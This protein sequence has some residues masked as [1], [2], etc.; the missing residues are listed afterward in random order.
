M[1]ALN[2]SRAGGA[3]RLEMAAWDSK[4]PRG[5]NQSAASAFHDFRLYRQI[6]PDFKESR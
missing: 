3:A 6:P 5:R 1:Q 4:W 2:F